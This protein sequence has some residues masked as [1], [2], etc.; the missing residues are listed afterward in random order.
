MDE[1]L[2]QQP[3]TWTGG[4]AHERTVC[5]HLVSAPAVLGDPNNFAIELALVR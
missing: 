5:D 4:A 3:R 2:F 1:L